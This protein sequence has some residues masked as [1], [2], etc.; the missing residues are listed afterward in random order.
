[1]NKSRMVNRIIFIFIKIILQCGTY[2]MRCKVFKSVGKMNHRLHKWRS[3]NAYCLHIF[4]IQ[5]C[6]LCGT[7]A[8]FHFLINISYFVQSW[9]KY[10]IGIKSI[11][12]CVDTWMYI[13]NIIIYGW[14]VET[15]KRIRNGDLDENVGTNSKVL[16]IKKP[17]H[18]VD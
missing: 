8:R 16:R 12:N 7:C 17:V 15:H 4:R 18:T 3:T 2:T 11:E 6:H 1:M 5:I 14:W 9:V 10:L 13:H